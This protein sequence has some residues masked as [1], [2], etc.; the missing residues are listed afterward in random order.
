MDTQIQLTP[1][2]DAEFHT[3]EACRKAL[4][5][6]IRVLVDLEPAMGER[7]SFN[8]TVALRFTAQALAVL[9]GVA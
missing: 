9:E 2:D 1:S 3:M 4:M 6:R 5:D 7:L 8:R